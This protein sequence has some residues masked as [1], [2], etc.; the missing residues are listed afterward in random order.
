M[1]FRSKMYETV[2]PENTASKL[3]AARVSK[4]KHATTYSVLWFQKYTHGSQRVNKTTT[5]QIIVGNNKYT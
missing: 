2:F 3:K 5:P 4:K 1:R